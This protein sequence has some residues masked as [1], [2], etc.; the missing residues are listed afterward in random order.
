MSS[1]Y[2]D[3]ISVGPFTD[4]NIV[5]D[6][7][8][9]AVQV[10]QAFTSLTNAGNYN[11][12]VIGYG[13][14]YI[15]PGNPIVIPGDLYNSALPGGGSFD[16][17]NYW[18]ASNFRGR[19]FTGPTNSP[20]DL[21]IHL[22]GSTPGDLIQIQGS[23][24]VVKNM[25]LDGNRLDANQATIYDATL[26]SNGINI[27]SSIGGTI[28]GGL[29][30]EI[31]N[32]IISDCASAGIRKDNSD[33]SLSHF[34]HI[35]GYTNWRDIWINKCGYGIYLSSGG[36]CII[37]NLT[38]SNP[39]KECIKFDNS[40]GYIQIIGSHC[41]QGANG[42]LSN[43]VAVS[44]F[45]AT[46]QCVYVGGYGHNIFI[47]CLFD[48]FNQFGIYLQCNG[49][50]GPT[51]GNGNQ[52]LGCHFDIGNPY[53]NASNAAIFCHGYRNNIIG[54]LY[55]DYSNNSYLQTGVYTDLQSCYNVIVGNSFEH[56]A[57]PVYDLY[58]SASSNVT[59]GNT[60]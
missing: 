35:T 12:A 53:Q 24:A 29:G 19:T 42:I 49:N 25:L 50:S 20:K 46:A 23:N 28:Y 31:E 45:Q 14:L 48:Y 47:N 17:V 6:G 43:S 22:T 27:I 2:D 51:D 16:S 33:G 60:A 5:T 34:S 10:N 37:N 58:A 4:C 1:K 30:C 32:I 7:I 18:T 56:C 52:I 9:D 13:D 44:I 54:N 55:N 11:G 40:A 15:A 26:A 57:Y 8:D 3:I 59:Y 38:I 36:D 41:W 21:R 39:Y